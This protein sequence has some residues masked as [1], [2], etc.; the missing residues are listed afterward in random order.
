[1]T[2]DPTKEYNVMFLYMDILTYKNMYLFAA[3]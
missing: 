2:P 3:F 1:M